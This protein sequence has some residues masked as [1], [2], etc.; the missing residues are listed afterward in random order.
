MYVVNR[1]SVQDEH[2]ACVNASY[3]GRFDTCGRSTE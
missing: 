3:L 2:F 1:V